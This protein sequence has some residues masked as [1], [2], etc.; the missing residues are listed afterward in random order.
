MYVAF[1]SAVHFRPIERMNKME[2]NGM[3]PS[4]QGICVMERARRKER[5]RCKIVSIKGEFEK[6]TWKLQEKLGYKEFCIDIERTQIIQAFPICHIRQFEKSKNKIVCPPVATFILCILFPLQ[7]FECLHTNA[8]E[9]VVCIIN[10]PG[11][12]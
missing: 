10:E 5:E 4:V 8:I 1:P 2:D 7:M 6:Y 3:S 11:E 12:K 9:C